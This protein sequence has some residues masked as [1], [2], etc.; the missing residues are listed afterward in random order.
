MRFL[1]WHPDERKERQ[2]RTDSTVR[3]A[4]QAKRRAAEVGDRVLK[5]ADSY[6]QID[7]RLCHR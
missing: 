6:R 1:C 3:R 7:E 5:V 2:A 4:E